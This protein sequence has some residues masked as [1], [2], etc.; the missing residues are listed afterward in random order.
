[1]T[2]TQLIIVCATVLALAALALSGSASRA[3]GAGVDTA[4]PRTGNRVTV[5]T[6]KPDDQTLFGVLVGDYA[7]RLVL[8]DAEYVTP[9]GGEPIPGVQHVATRDIAWIDVHA[10]VAA[11]DPAGP[12]PLSAA[13]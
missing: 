2:T 8:E 10:L 4:P 1:V 6:K 3:Q 11:P 13:S 9:A 5:H 7:D 12:S